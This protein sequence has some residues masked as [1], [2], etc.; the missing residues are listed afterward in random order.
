M[1]VVDESL[2]FGWPPQFGTELGLFLWPLDSIAGLLRGR[3]DRLSHSLLA[4]L[5]PEGS[6]GVGCT[7]C[8]HSAQ[9]RVANPFDT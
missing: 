9:C 4:L 7:Q 2:A 6:R 5:R 1:A 8:T 3:R